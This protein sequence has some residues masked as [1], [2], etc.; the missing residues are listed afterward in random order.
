MAKMN[1]EQ[2]FEYVLLEIFYL[3]LKIF[4]LVSHSIM[5][6]SSR[7]QIPRI[8]DFAGKYLQYLPF[9]RFLYIVKIRIQNC[10]WP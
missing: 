4:S 8:L 10:Y 7:N 5:I 9:M 1:F 3:T 2:G 6:L